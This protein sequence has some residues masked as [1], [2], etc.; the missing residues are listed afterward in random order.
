M[1]YAK[2]IASLVEKVNSLGTTSGEKSLLLEKICSLR[3]K[4]GLDMNLAIRASGTSPEQF[5]MGT[6]KLDHR[7]TAHGPVCSLLRKFFSVK[8][9]SKTTEASVE[10]TILGR[11]SNVMLARSIYLTLMSMFDQA[12]LD[13]CL[14]LKEKAK[15]YKGLYVG[16]KLALTK[17]SK[18]ID[19][20]G[21][22]VF[23]KNEETLLEEYLLRNFPYAPRK[24]S[25]SVPAWAKEK[26]SQGGIEA[27]K[28]IS[29][30][31][32]IKD[33]RALYIKG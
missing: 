27:G 7:S 14:P 16:Q 32:V 28:R 29:S 9:V 10:V 8:V 17:S 20:P 15:F 33:G 13:S 11:R 2:V 18:G 5:S 30:K 22:V 3:K 4:H 12:W 1:D 31:P 23:E 26:A 21:L 19:E 24:R 6:F 25:N